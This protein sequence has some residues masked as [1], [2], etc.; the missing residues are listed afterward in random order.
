[1]NSLTGGLVTSSAVHSDSVFEEKGP[2]PIRPHGAGSYAGGGQSG[3]VEN[4][5]KAKVVQEMAKYC[6]CVDPT[7]ADM[8]SWPP[9]VSI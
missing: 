3:T 7:I 6:G 1:M 2:S 9:S 5:L 8:K 4:L